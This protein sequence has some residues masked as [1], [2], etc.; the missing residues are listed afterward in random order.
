MA[1]RYA[2]WSYS[3]RSQRVDRRRGDDPFQPAR[4]LGVQGYER[5]CLQLSERNV[6]GVV[7][8]GPPQPL[9][10]VPGPTPEHCVAEEADRYSPDAGEPV[11]GD[12]RRH[13]A[14]VHGLVQ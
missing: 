3:G 2:A 12:I 8:L 1:T 14:L 5:V 10:E 13:L 6:L 4:Q 11:E 7:G 9:G